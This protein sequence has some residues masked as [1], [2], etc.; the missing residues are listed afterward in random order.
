M[1]RKCSVC[2]SDRLL[3][4][5]HEI[6][7]TRGVKQIQANPFVVKLAKADT[8]A[9]VALDFL[10]QVVGNSSSIFDAADSLA[11]AGTENQAFCDHRLARAALSN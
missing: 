9:D 7:I 6:R 2:D 4:L 5:R 3:C 8:C 1:T 10:I 11:R